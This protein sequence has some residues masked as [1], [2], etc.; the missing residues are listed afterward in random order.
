MRRPAQEAGLT[1]AQLV[2]A[3]VLDHGQVSSA[4]AGATSDEQL[5][6][7]LGAGGVDLDEELRRR[8]D[9]LFGE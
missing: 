6:E 5:R 2:L 4:I 9:G 8:L 3:W 1:R 7:S